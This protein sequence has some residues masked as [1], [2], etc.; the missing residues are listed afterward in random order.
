MPAL[1]T[2]LLGDDYLQ[3]TDT[4]LVDH[5]FEFLQSDIQRIQIQD[6]YRLRYLPTGALIRHRGTAFEEVWVTYDPHF[7]NLET[8]VYE[9]VNRKKY[10]VTRKT[11]KDNPLHMRAFT[12]DLINR[13][14][15]QQSISSKHQL[16]FELLSATR[17]RF[18]IHHT[19]GGKYQEKSCSLFCEFVDDDLIVRSVTTPNSK[20]SMREINRKMI[21]RSVKWKEYVING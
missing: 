11:Y 18:D 1:Q 20:V 19:Y 9:K 17:I 7:A 12:I 21:D 2:K 15:P 6:E 5:R 10:A 14:V 13:L 8:A 4:F 3:D 16:G